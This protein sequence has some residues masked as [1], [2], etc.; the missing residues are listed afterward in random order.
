MMGQRQMVFVRNNLPIRM[1]LIPGPPRERDAL[2]MSPCG[3]LLESFYIRLGIIRGNKVL[4]FVERR[5][6]A[7][8]T[9]HGGAAC[10]Q[11][12]HNR[13]RLARDFRRMMRKEEIR[14]AKRT[15]NIF[16]AKFP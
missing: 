10:R 12:S 6:V 16:R 15:G 2:Q 1:S 3:Q 8:I 7:S 4:A 14:I 5:G 9:Q 11:R 13:P